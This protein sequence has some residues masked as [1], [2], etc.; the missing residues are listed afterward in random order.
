MRIKFEVKTAANTNSAYNSKFTIVMEHVGEE[1]VRILITKPTLQ[2]MRLYD[3][4]PAIEKKDIPISDG[5]LTM[6]KVNLKK[7]IAALQLLAKN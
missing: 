3:K 5:I 6:S 4:N 1:G 7:F 2:E